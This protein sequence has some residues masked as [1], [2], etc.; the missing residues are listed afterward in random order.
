MHLR[1]IGIFFTAA[2]VTPSPPSV[3]KEKKKVIDEVG[4]DSEMRRAVARGRIA[5]MINF[6]LKRNFSIC[7]YPSIYIVGA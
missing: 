5:L 3:A 7:V 6:C 2:A 1:D 4:L